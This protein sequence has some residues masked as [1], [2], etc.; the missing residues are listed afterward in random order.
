MK[1]KVVLSLAITV[2]I[3]STVL[4][5]SC[6]HHSDSSL[7]T[8]NNKHVRTN[9]SKY[10]EA[11]SIHNEILASILSDNNTYYPY[12]LYAHINELGSGY[13]FKN[14]LPF[15]VFNQIYTNSQGEIY[16]DELVMLNE[17]V[18][19]NFITGVFP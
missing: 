12:E 19:K 15:D 9:T 7:I 1:K 4:Y 8:K 2:T 3:F 10:E 5:F 11:G 17:L 18:N 14:T 13:G 6:T 16:S